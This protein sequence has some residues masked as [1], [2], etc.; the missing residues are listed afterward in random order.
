MILYW[1]GFGA[2]KNRLR[3]ATLVF[4]HTISVFLYVIKHKFYF[5]EKEN[6]NLINI[7]QNSNFHRANGFAGDFSCFC[8]PQ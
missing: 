6:I 4:Y 8:R 5:Q 7:L 2:E 1:E 3:L